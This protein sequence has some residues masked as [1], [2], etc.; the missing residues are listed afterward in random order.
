MPQ[1]MEKRG[2]K[3]KEKKVARKGL[4]AQVV[5]EPPSLPGAIS[6]FLGLFGVLCVLAQLIVRFQASV[7]A[8]STGV[9]SKFVHYLSKG[10]IIPGV[11]GVVL[12]LLCLCLSARRK[13][14]GW[15]GLALSFGVVVAWLLLG[16]HQLKW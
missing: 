14:N 5:V 7:T 15:F 10:Q 4:N 13:G 16:N 6:L 3:K 9:E 1:V 11:L 8:G 2:R 12:A